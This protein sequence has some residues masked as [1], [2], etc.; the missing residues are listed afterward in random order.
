MDRVDPL[1]KEYPELTPYQFA[2]NTPI[3]AIDL[4]GLEACGNPI[5]HSRGLTGHN[6]QLSLHKDATIKEQITQI[7][8]MA[9]GMG[10][11]L[12]APVTIPFAAWK[13]IQLVAWAPAN[14]E[15]IKFGLGVVG[16]MFFDGPDDLVSGSNGDELVK[17]FKGSGIKV[18]DFFGGQISKY[19]G[20]LNIDKEAIQGYK[21]T[22]SSFTKFMAENKLLGTVDK[23]IADNPFGYDEY[24]NDAASLLKSGGIITISGNESNKY[25]NKILK[26]TMAGLENFDVIPT[27]TKVSKEGMK[28]SEGKDI[29]KDMYQITLKRK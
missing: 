6:C 11:V 27:V 8:G 13:G 14:I 19:A 1:T 4:D 15:T 26:G 2:S 21:G 17:A 10:A 9:L 5:A 29:V 22:I 18:L 3:Y 20:A 23:I 12:T 28:T 16:G 24:L 7:G 25:F